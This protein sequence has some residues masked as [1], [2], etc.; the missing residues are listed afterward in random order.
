MKVFFFVHAGVDNFSAKM[1]SQ[2]GVK[3]INKEF[4]RKLKEDQFSLYYGT[5]G[6][7]IRTKS[8]D[9]ERHFSKNGS[10][11]M[12]NSGINAIVHGH[13]NLYY[14]QRI[15]LRKVIINFECDT[16]LDINMR[17]KEGVVQVL[18]LFI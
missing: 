2:H 1:I 18:V 14:G 11:M 15:M 3:G 10:L 4:R 13:R 5:L 7:M 6:N 8:R 9:Y 16:S 12:Y 17:K